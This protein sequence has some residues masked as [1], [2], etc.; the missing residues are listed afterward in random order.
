M[1]S[2]SNIQR[3]LFAIMKFVDLVSPW[4]IWH[5][6][7]VFRSARAWCLCSGALSRRVP[8]RAS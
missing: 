1:A 3:V 8:F 2:R 7:N 5:W 4:E 6:F